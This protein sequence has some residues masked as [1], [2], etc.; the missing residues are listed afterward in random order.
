MSINL[1]Q[2][3]Q[4]VQTNC[5]I[6]DA[7]HAGEDT[8]CVYLLKMRELY[9]WE[10]GLGFDQEPPKDTLGDWLKNREALWEALEEAAFEDLAVSE[11]RYDPFDAAAINAALAPHALVYSAGLG[12]GAKPHFFLGELE[13]EER[14]NG[15]R[16]YVAGREFARDLGAPPAMSQ[17][18]HIY[19]RRES[20]RRMLWERVEEW[21]WNRPETPMGRAV[22]C[23]DFDADINAALEAMTANELESALLHELGELK[24]GEQLGPEWE[25]MLIELP[26]SKAEFIARAV[27]DLLADCL[28]TLPG[29]LEQ[30]NVAALHFY[31][32]NLGGMRKEL[33]PGF[34]KAYRRWLENDDPA[35]L[36]ALIEQGRE[37]WRDVGRTLLALYREHGTKA[38]SPMADL[39]ERCRL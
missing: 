18:K 39:S 10:Q 6:A 15:Y 31:A 4:D 20:L 36:H 11:T 19:I 32:G 38:L 23:Y 22:A 21:R 5:N 34:L 27:R 2:L 3:R 35:P 16:I 12:R 29:L 8:L 30:D 17:G 28:S 37:H 25:D 26:R 24:A 14:H 33:F 9:R 1:D 13:R 7:R